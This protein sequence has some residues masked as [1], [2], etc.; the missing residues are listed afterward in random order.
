MTQDPAF[1][2]D[3]T[4][5]FGERQWAILERVL[6][7]PKSGRDGIVLDGKSV[8]C[9]D[10]ILRFRQHSGYNRSFE[11][12]WRAFQLNQYDSV[13]G[14]TLYR[15]RYKLMSGWPTEGLGGELILEAGCGAGAF[16]CHLVATGADLVSFDY[17]GA[18]EVAAQHNASPRAV[19]AQA[20]LL[21]MPFREGSF[22][23]VFCHGV[24]QHTPDP[25]A[26]FRALD[27]CLKIGGRMSIDI[28]AKDGRI[29]TYKAKYLWRPITTRME[30]ER[31]MAFLRRFIP[32]WL[33][34]D[35]VIKR[36]PFFG[37]YL[38][39][40]VP[41][42]N[43]FWTDLSAEQKREWAIMNTFDALAP[44]YDL[45]ATEDEVRGW[46]EAAGYTDLFVRNYHGFVHGTGRK[47]RP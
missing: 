30:P 8:P 22:D 25:A 34:L 31:L 47:A 44:P 26:G 24:L 36:V 23:R 6:E 38:G 11:L 37:R 42:M 35:T 18:V 21:D 43:Y 10:G 7:A 9:R 5:G 28:Y 40:V 19:F 27:R 1:A 4:A 29:E 3:A 32:L 2:A 13:N 41:C 12:Q 45:P 14:T 39:A 16:T 15:D 46:F 20:D 17:S 33:P